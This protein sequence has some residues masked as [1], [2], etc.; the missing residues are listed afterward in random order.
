MYIK[1]ILHTFKYWL[2]QYTLHLDH[3]IFK[4]EV[5]NLHERFH[6]MIQGGK[7]YSIQ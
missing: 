2:Y 6:G 5:E 1:E 7:K 3:N 4:K